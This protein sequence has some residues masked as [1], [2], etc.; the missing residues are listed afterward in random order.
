MIKTLGLLQEFTDYSEQ[1]WQG[2]VKRADD[3]QREIREELQ[4][5]CEK[6]C[7]KPLKFTTV[8]GI[9]TYDRGATLQM[10]NDV[11]DTHI[12]SVI[13]NIAQ[14]VDRDWP[15]EIDNHMF[16]RR[17]V[18]LRPGEML[19]YEGARLPHGRPSPLEG[20]YYAN[21]FVH[22]EPEDYRVPGETD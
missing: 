1:D 2:D 10:H 14:Q 22:F 13:M 6:W 5:I 12:I 21:V 18:L 3:L 9:R 16:R 17:S 15:L 8:Y 19:L 11:E 20:E 7:G 4:P